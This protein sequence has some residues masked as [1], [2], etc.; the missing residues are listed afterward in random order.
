[1]IGS[2]KL[3]VGGSPMIDLSKASFNNSYANS[4]SLFDKSSL[5]RVSLVSFG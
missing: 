2:L 5:T 4:V 1:M 3:N